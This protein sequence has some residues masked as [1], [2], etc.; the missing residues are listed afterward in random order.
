LPGRGPGELA[1]IDF[2]DPEQAVQ[3]I[4]LHANGFNALTY[5]AMLEPLGEDARILALDQRGHGRSTLET[6][7]EGRRSWLDLCD[8][9]LAFLDA[10]DLTDV[11]LA[12]HSMGGAV[13]IFAAAGAPRRVRRLLLLDPVMPPPAYRRA[14]SP[15]PSPLVA[16]ALKRRAVF[17]DREAV[18]ETYRSRSAFKSWSPQMLADYVT[19]GFI[20][21]PTGEVTLACRPE[22][23]SS[24]F[25]AQDQ[26]VWAAAPHT[27]CPIAILKAEFDSTCFVGDWAQAV[28]ADGRV[29]I[30]TIA[31]AS[32]FL[33]MERPDLCREALDVALKA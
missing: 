17:P 16:G 7:T 18:I 12:G 29:T 8:D 3:L 30:E 24:S 32:H 13:S 19:D 2:G 11:I 23:E 9:L 10:L 31:G 28:T 20:D 15:P 27:V 4:F 21:L 14:A 33:P 25:A 26:D 5:R 6:R 22:W 1:L